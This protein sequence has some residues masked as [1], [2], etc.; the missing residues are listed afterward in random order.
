[1]GGRGRRISEFEASLVYSV[2]SRTARA[3]QKKPCLEKTKNKKRKKKM[4]EM[5]IQGSSDC[6]PQ[7][8][9]QWKWRTEHAALSLQ[10]KPGHVVMKSGSSLVIQTLKGKR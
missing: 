8:G 6:K 9:R 2:S 1:L 5:D 3:T 4:T 10:H 7:R